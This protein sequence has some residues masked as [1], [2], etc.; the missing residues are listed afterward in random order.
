[1]LRRDRDERD[2]LV[3][4]RDD[5]GEQIRRSRAR[6][7]DHHTDLPRGLVEPFGHVGPRGLVPDR[8]EADA[9]VV[10]RRQQRVDL[11]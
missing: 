8:H 7:A 11:G 6:V 3:P 10:E 5:A 4:G 9:V 1:V 2:A